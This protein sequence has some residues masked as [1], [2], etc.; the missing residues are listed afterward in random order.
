MRARALLSERK[1]KM[2]HA[3]AEQEAVVVLHLV[4][5]SNITK[6]PMEVVKGY[7]DAYIQQGAGRF[8]TREGAAREFRKYVTQEK[9]YPRTFK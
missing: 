5:V 6:D 3:V 2:A 9:E 1:T 8:M 4:R 7:F